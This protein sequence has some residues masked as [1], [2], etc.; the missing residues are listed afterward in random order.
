MN[1]TT[2]QNF[3][4]DV[5][6]CLLKAKDALFNTVDSLSTETAAGSFPELSLSPFFERCW[7]SLYEAFEDGQIDREKLLNVFATFA[8]LPKSGEPFWIGIDTSNIERPFSRTSADRTAVY[9]HNLP[10][11]KKPITF[12][13][14]FST[15]V[16]LPE[17]PSSWAYILDQVRVHSTTTAVQV[18]L[19]QLKKLKHLLPREM[20]VVLDRGYDSLWFWS[21]LRKEKINALIRLKRNWCFYRP[22]LPPSPTKKKKGPARKDGEKWQAKDPSTYGIPD[23]QWAGKD[24]KSHPI[25]V[26]WWNRM[27][28]QQAR[29]LEMTVIR[30]IRVKVTLCGLAILL[31][32]LLRSLWDMSV[33]LVRNI[34]IVSR[35]SRYFGQKHVYGLLNSLN[36]GPLLLLLHKIRFS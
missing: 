26:E 28:M 9:K 17:V 16:M 15:I 27:H 4:H 2:L 3:R 34:A 31:L 29:W 35:S 33:V 25:Q 32:I 6:A 1:F 24:A 14:S 12:G 36:Y 5:Y 23:G 8:P 19:D 11:C 18:A 22:P 10:E 21:Q 13:W 30:V 7:P 20:I